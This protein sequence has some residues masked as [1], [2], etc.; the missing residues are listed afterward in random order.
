[1]SATFGGAHDLAHPRVAEQVWM[2]GR[3]FAGLAVGRGAKRQDADVR[4]FGGRTHNF[5]YLLP[6]DR[7]R[8]TVAST[9]AREEQRLVVGEPVFLGPEQE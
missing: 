1:M 6:T 2:Q 4:P 3:R 8:C 5:P 7:P 9:F